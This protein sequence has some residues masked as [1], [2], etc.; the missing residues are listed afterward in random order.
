M[1]FSVIDEETENFD[2]KDLQKYEVRMLLYF[3]TVY[4]RIIGPV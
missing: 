3:V 2:S 1:D 4:E